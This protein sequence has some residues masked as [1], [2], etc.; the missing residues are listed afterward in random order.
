[1]HNFV[2]QI[3]SVPYPSFKVMDGVM[4]TIIFHPVTMIKVT[5]VKI[6]SK[7]IIAL[8][9]HALMEVTVKMSVW[10][11][12]LIRLIVSIL[13]WLVMETVMTFQT[14]NSASLTVV[15]VVML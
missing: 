12:Q 1:M 3:R 11:Q 2:F 15:I 10:V 5:V 7:L 6:L 4:M 8:Y 13:I 9:V 14:L